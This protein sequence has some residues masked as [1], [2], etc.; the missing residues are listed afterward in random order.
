MVNEA[1]LVSP[2]S[3]EK[4][5]IKDGIF[6][7]ISFADYKFFTCFFC[8]EPVAVGLVAGRFGPRAVGE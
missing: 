5:L 2:F 8:C 4:F 7:P 1:L 6:H 3:A